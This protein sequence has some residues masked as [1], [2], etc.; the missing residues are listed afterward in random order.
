[1]VS[2]SPRPIVEAAASVM[3]IS[4]A[5]VI[6]ATAVLEG[7]RFAA[8]V[9]RPIPYGAGKASALRTRLGDLPLL[10]AF[11]DNAFDAE[12]LSASARPIAVR[13]KIRLLQR[14]PEIRGMRQLA[15]E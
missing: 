5:N 8:S 6:A 10:A 2:A 14:A 13:P 11:G 12:M 9:H 15:V 7:D 1:V 3:G 4:Q